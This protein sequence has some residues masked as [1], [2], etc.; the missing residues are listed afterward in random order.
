M[1]SGNPAPLLYNYLHIFTSYGETIL[2]I[3]QPPREKTSFAPIEKRGRT[4][5]KT[6]IGS[7]TGI[8]IRADLALFSP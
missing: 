1:E 2:V 8:V 7:E 5:V 3:A 4:R 6:S